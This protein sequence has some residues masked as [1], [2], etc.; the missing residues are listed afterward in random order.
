MVRVSGSS[1]VVSGRFWCVAI[2]T[3]MGAIGAAPRADAA[4]YYVQDPGFGFFRPIPFHHHHHKPRRPSV[5]K[6]TLEKEAAGKPQGALII[7]VSL[8]KQQLKVYDA[9][10]FYAQSPVSSG[11]PGHATPMG[12]FSVIQKHKL[13]HSNIYSNAPM[14]YMQRITWSG[15]ALHAGVLP[16]YPASHGCIR[17]PTGFA[18]KMWNW[19]RMGAR[20][21]V[22]PGELS[23]A[24]FS[25]PLLPSFKIAPQPVIAVQPMP[26][27][28][29]AAKA[30]KGAPEAKPSPAAANVELRSTVGHGDAVT[31]VTFREQTHTADAAD[32]KGVVTMSDAPSVEPLRE[33]H[34]S[35]TAASTTIVDVVKTEAIET[36]KPDD[37]KPSA[38]DNNAAGAGH[39]QTDSVDGKAD[40]T[41]AGAVTADD[42]PSDTKAA[43]DTAAVPDTDARKDQSRLLKPDARKRTGQIAVFISR[44][45][46]KIYVRQNFAPLFQAPV[47]IAASDRPLGTHIFTV[48]VDRTDPNVLHWSVVSVPMSNRSLMRARDGVRGA[49]RHKTTVA[50]EAKPLPAADSAAEAL[51]RITV[52]ADVMA[53]IAE[54]LTTGGS[55]IVSD[56]G[57]NQG[58]TGEGTDFIVSLR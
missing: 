30:D 44:K 20:V 33:G 19:T 21:I 27:E 1:S 32:A 13:H 28:P 11:M 36:G 50:E 23:P 12:V 24:S 9:N 6:D 17:M 38:A 26:D 5:K 7:A 40:T 53:R 8:S 10:G 46:S 52:P 31:P 2:L 34:G 57:I 14:P 35:D 48:D 51:D 41:K 4:F 29:V 56:Q 25:H 49:R 55:I 37:A 42:K 54:V 16:G 18:I 45:D 15:V 43:D 3:A 47:S 22:T 39:A 58:E